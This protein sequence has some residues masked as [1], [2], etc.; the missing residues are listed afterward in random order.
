MYLENE[1]LLA[2]GLSMPI[3]FFILWCLAQGIRYG[4]DVRRTLA[5]M[6]DNLWE[7]NP[8]HIYQAFRTLERDGLVTLADVVAQASF[9]DRKEY[10]VTESG[11]AA[12]AVW[13]ATPVPTR[14]SPRDETILKLVLLTEQNQPEALARF[15]AAQRWRCEQDRQ[16]LVV[17]CATLPSDDRRGYLIAQAGIA[18]IDAHLNWLAHLEPV[19]AR[20]A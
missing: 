10:T 5:E 12:L 15:L 20:T 13:L 7:I 4:Y 6:T 19:A 2:Q 17:H 11:R 9:P 18:A 3:R 14:S 8:G 1:V 16:R